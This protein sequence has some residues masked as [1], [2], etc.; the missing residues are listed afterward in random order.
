MS[1]NFSVFLLNFVIYLFSVTAV[2]NKFF[3]Q[4]WGEKKGRVI[5]F[6]F[7]GFMGCAT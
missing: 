3:Q 1:P 2:C 5:D 7:L 4:F 6:H